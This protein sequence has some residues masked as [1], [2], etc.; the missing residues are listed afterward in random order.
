MGALSRSAIF[1]NSQFVSTTGIVV[2]FAIS[3]HAG[4]MI[5]IAIPVTSVL[6]P[7][8][9]IPIVMG[10]VC[11]GVLYARKNHVMQMAMLQARL[12]QYLSLRQTCQTGLSV[13]L[14]LKRKRRR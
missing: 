9:P 11:G 5:F 12:V 7:C 6:F 13:K 3:K 1:V 8:V 10:I 4:F 2:T 14:A